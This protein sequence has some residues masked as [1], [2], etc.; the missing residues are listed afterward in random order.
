MSKKRPAKTRSSRPSVQKV[1]PW[2]AA[3]AILAGAVGMFLMAGSETPTPVVTPHHVSG[4]LAF[5]DVTAQAREFMAYNRTIE[6]TAAQESVKRQ[7]LSHMAAPCC[8]DYSAYTCCCECNL[9]RTVWGLSNHLIAQRGY[10]AEQVSA[11][12]TE[13]L[14]F[15]NP[16]GFGGNA[17]FDG[18]CGRPFDKDG[19]GGMNEAHFV[20]S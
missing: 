20:T 8:S 3:L 15:V 6:L 2:V 4:P 11:T 14:N 10:D 13:W 12:V 7:A 1:W 16:Q 17:C 5:N 18:G 19:C 9:S